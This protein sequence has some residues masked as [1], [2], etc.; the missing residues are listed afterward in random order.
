MGD[1]DT[2]DN[3]CD[4]TSSDNMRVS[5]ERGKSAL[6]SPLMIMFLGIARNVDRVSKN[7]VGD[8]ALGRL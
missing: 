1:R 3:A 2:N 5:G 6:K 4:L 7:C 8:A